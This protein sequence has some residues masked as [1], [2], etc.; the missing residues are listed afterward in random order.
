MGVK[1]SVG[2]SAFIF[3]EYESNPVPLK[4][5]VGRLEE[6]DFQGIELVGMKPYGDPDDISSMSDRRALKKMFR[7]HGLEISN[8]GADFKRRSPASSDPDEREDY[9]GLFTKNLTFCVDCEIP[10]MRV[11]TV[12]EPPLKPGVQ[13]EDAWKRFVDTWQTGAERALKEG[14]LIVWE[15]EPGF[16]FNRPSE[17]I[18]MMEDVGHSNFK[19]LFDSCHAHMCAARG[20]RQKDPVETLSGGEVE[21]AGRLKGRIGYVHLIDSD[22]TLHDNW[23]ST[24]APFGTG[25][26]DFDALTDT[27]VESGYDG[28][29]WT[30]DLCFWSEAWNILAESKGFIDRLLKRHEL[31]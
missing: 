20:A 24:H 26:I 10:S 30:I 31:L 13:Y 16:Q 29:W 5:L 6:L 28:E 2:S 22:D 21:L 4:T 23:T 19:L 3:G 27:I 15:F 7:D 11:D 18:R 17:I 14:V 8:Y 1:V 25:V 12:D 9:N